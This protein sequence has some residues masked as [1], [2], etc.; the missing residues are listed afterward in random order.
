MSVFSF[1]CLF[2][3]NAKEFR[4]PA[5]RLCG[6]DQI[7]SPPALLPSVC[8]LISP[9]HLF[10]TL[11]EPLVL[12]FH[13]LSHNVYRQVIILSFQPPL[14]IP[15]CTIHTN[16]YRELFCFCVLLP[17]GLSTASQQTHQYHLSRKPSAFP[18]PFARLYVVLPICARHRLSWY[19]T[20]S[21]LSSLA[22]AC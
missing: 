10:S 18:T 3:A 15:V 13:M 1:C 2:G 20:N 11:A 6:P 12:I 19:R 22:A 14:L 16:L 5:D 8:L 17:S 21:P 4:S 7:I 9:P